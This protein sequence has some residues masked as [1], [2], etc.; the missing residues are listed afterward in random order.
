[1]RC[2]G[3]GLAEQPAQTDHIGKA[4]DHPRRCGQAVT[5]GASRFLI[6][7]FDAFRRVKVS[8]KTHIWFVNPHSK[9]HRGDN[10]NA[11]FSHKPCLVLAP[12]SSIQPRV[13]GERGNAFAD[14]PCRCVFHPFAAQTINNSSIFRMFFADEIQE[15]GA[16]A[17]LECDSILNVR[18]VKSGS[19]YG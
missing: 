4:V 10:H 14:Q 6:V 18:A 19:K 1:M 13:V 3:F 12:D 2:I 16:R 9:R 5:P 8:D 17:V 11:F 15:L 7:G